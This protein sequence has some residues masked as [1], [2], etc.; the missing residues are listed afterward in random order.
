MCGLLILSLVYLSPDFQARLACVI[1]VCYLFIHISN[2]QAI[3]WQSVD[4]VLQNEFRLMITKWM[5]EGVCEKIK[6]CVRICMYKNVI[7]ANVSLCIYFLIPV[8]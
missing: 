5:C 2:L 6:W 7:R 8:R 3:I 1:Q 4:K